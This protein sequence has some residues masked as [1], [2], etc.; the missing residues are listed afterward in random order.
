MVE[1]SWNSRST[2]MSKSQTEIHHVIPPTTWKLNN[3]S[4]QKLGYTRSTMRR[5]S[6]YYN[7]QV[8]SV[9]AAD[10]KA[11]DLHSC[12]AKTS[13]REQSE[14]QN[15][16]LPLEGQFCRILLKALQEHASYLYFTATLS[17]GDSPFILAL[18]YPAARRSSTV[19]AIL[20]FCS[21]SS[22]VST[23]TDKISKT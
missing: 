3:N 19:S 4:A 15:N 9:R 20:T 16:C 23:F 22:R 8:S 21:S 11:F 1:F 17:N 18:K 12:P 7:N 2:S 13:V 6:L 14:T 5:P 10:I